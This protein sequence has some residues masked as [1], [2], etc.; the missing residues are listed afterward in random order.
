MRIAEGGAPSCPVANDFTLE[1]APTCSG[2]LAGRLAGPPITS[3]PHHSWHAGLDGL[4]LTGL[5]LLKMFS[6]S[7]GSVERSYSS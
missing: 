4:R 5:A 2:R 1:Q 7:S 6:V 3:T